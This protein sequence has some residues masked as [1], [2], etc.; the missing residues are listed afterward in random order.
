[1]Y[2]ISKY[3]GKIQI[4]NVIF[5][6]DEREELYPEYLAFLQNEGTPEF[7]D[8]LDGEV[9]IPKVPESISRM[10]LKI[11]LLLKNIEIQ[12][13]IDTINSI[14]NSMFPDIDK[15]IAIIKFQDASYYDRYNADFN[16]VA[17]LIGLSQ[18]ELDEIFINGNKL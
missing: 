11:Q 13:V 9:E 12:D 5:P 16:L 1:M 6:Q 17:T 3:S 7:V 15:K 4:G 2:K 10:G 14:P 8:F 18:D